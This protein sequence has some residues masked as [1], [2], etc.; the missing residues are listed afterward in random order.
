M[1]IFETE[2]RAAIAA[3]QAE[4]N[5]TQGD[6]IAEGDPHGLYQRFGNRLDAAE[7]ALQAVLEPV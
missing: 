6:I 7:K 1:T 2:I 3:L 4:K 5:L